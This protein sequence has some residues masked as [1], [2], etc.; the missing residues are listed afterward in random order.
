MNT[1]SAFVVAALSAASLVTSAYGSISLVAFQESVTLNFSTAPNP[2]DLSTGDIE[3][4]ASPYQSVADMD[5]LVQGASI[6][7]L[8]SALE[9]V[10]QFTTGSAPMKYHS[11]DG[12]IYSRPK[13][14]GNS[15]IGASLL[16]ATLQNNT[17][18]NISL[19]QVAYEY[20]RVDGVVAETVPGLRAYYS[21]TGAANSWQLIS[22]LSVDTTATPSSPDQ[23]STDITLSTP[24]VSGSNLYLLWADDNVKFDDNAYKIDNL[25]FTALAGSVTIPEP[26][27]ALFSGLGVCAL[28][29]RRRTIQ[30]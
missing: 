21:F 14:S 24:W 22:P 26:S 8:T 19:L 5:A 16:L 12:S 6:D 30:A 10:N 9:V 7:D 15:G 20:S 25:S 29:L 1:S 3:K 2:S 17:G 23:L 11:T 13:N 28:L 18:S 27:I 4:S